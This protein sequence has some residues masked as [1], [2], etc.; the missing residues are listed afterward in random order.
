MAFLHL[1]AGSR[2]GQEMGKWVEFSRWIPNDDSLVVAGVR[3]P[4]SVIESWQD[5]FEQ[6]GI[7][8]RIEQKAG[9]RVLCRWIEDES[10][11]A[12]N[13]SVEKQT[14]ECR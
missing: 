2:K 9:G 1:T 3:I 7:P 14:G 12:S 8:T 11:D 13:N 5:W 4:S 6:S 10:E